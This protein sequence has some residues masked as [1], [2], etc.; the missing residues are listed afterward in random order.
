M[1]RINIE[2]CWWSDPRR[3]K[4]AVIVGSQVSADGMA[5]NAWRMAQ[6]FWKKERQLVPRSLFEMLDGAADLLRVGLADSREEMVYI[7]GSSAYL[8]WLNQS[9]E[10]GREGGLVSAQRPRDE[11]GRLLPKKTQAPSKPPLDGTPS[12]S[13]RL[14]PSSSSSSSNTN[15]IH[16]QRKRCST[17]KP[18]FDLEKLYQGYPRKKG[19]TPG[20]KKLTKEILSEKDFEELAAAVKNYA[21][22]AA[23]KESQYVMH[24]STFASQWRDWIDVEPDTQ[25]YS[26]NTTPIDLEAI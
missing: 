18:L 4:L 19:K 24:F 13:K 14:Q 11:K 8:D 22:E 21:K 7:R 5:M 1:A 23:T 16:E 26:I 25:Q 2:D 9:K 17:V 20:L 6:E 15:T 10:A 12:D 3:G